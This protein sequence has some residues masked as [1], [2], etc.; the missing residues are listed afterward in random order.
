MDGVLRRARSVPRG[1]AVGGHAGRSPRRPTAAP[2]APAASAAH[3]T[4]AAARCACRPRRRGGGCRGHPPP[5]QR[6]G[7]GR[8]RGRRRR[9][10][11]DPRGQGVRPVRRRRRAR[12]RGG[13]RHRRNATTY[14]PTESYRTAPELG[15]PGVGLVLDTGAPVQ[16]HRL[17]FSTS[18]PGLTAEILAGDSLDGPFDAVVGGS[19]TVGSARPR[20]VHD[21]RRRAPLLRDLDHAA[22]QRLPERAHQR[23]SGGLAQSQ[24]VP[25]RDAPDRLAAPEAD[26]PL[27]QREVARR[28]RDAQAG[29]NCDEA[30]ELARRRCRFERLTR[31]GVDR[32]VRP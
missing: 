12:F 24:C 14:W 11:P 20:R 3:L 18:T 19:Q 4:V 22:R 26:R 7:Y 21:R 28:H 8:E 13:T 5:A 29:P 25:D 32:P 23:S 15:K 9:F 31:Q 17:G 30:D 2:A 1:A 27:A 16:L 10:R 6:L